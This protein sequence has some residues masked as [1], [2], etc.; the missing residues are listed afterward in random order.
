MCIVLL[1]F[2]EAGLFT[3][4]EPHVKLLGALTA[5]TLLKVFGDAVGIDEMAVHTTGYVTGSHTIETVSV[6]E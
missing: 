3:G 4:T 5:K 1:A 6:I 2:G